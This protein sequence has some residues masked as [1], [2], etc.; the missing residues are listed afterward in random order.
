[1]PRIEV[2]VEIE[3]IEGTRDTVRIVVED[4]R[5]ST[6]SLAIV[7]TKLLAKVT[8]QSYAPTGTPNG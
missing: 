4:P 3:A 6:E 7:V 2:E 8:N 5:L 1:M